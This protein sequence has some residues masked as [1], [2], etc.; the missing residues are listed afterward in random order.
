MTSTIYDF[1]T[2]E[3]ITASRKPLK[4]VDGTENTF[5]A[6]T[7]AAGAALRPPGYLIDG[8]I[9]DNGRVLLF[10]ES[11]AY[12]S[13]LAV[14]LA[15]SL[16]TGRDYHGIKAKRRDVV[17]IASESG[18]SVAAKR[19]PGWCHYHGI[20]SESVRLITVSEQVIFSRHRQD[21]IAKLINTCRKAE[22]QTPIFVV[23]VLGASIL[24]SINADDVI[25]DYIAAQNE[26]GTVLGAL[27]IS[28]AHTNWTTSDRASG[29]YQL[30]A[31]HETR[32]R[33]VRDDPEE[34]ETRLEVLRMKD[35]EPGEPMNFSLEIVELGEHD[36]KPLSTLV[37][38]F[39]Q[40]G[41]P[42]RKGSDQPQGAN[43]CALW[44]IAKD[45]AARHGQ[46]H[47]GSDR[48]PANVIVIDEIA[49]REECRK[50][51]P[52]DGKH[53]STTFNRAL[54]G[55]INKGLMAKYENN[56]WIV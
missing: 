49:L 54:A 55:V 37:P 16:A 47:Q 39:K 14:D 29:N 44:E 8:L 48:I 12:K 15:C 24:G 45:T 34:R 27:W 5:Q 6:F 1:D 23:D 32:L 22:V 10:G 2:L 46:R 51:M 11:D 41:K 21:N 3:N 26:I 17:Y 19:V 28:V 20:Q 53:F 33:V 18:Y 40:Y 52:H 13:F 38:V 43:Q 31:Q 30:W 7:V 35:D 9:P 56:I 36:G 4:P 50:R 25:G 42:P